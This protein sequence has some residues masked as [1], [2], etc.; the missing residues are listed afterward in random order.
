M[1]NMQSLPNKMD[2]LLSCIQFEH[3][4]KDCS[5]YCFTET[6]LDINTL[7]PAIQPQGF[8][9]FHSDCLRESTGKT[10]GGVICFLI[11]ENWCTDIDIIMNRICTADLECFLIK[12]R[13]FYLPWEFSAVFLP[14]VNIHPQADALTALD[15]L[16]DIVH[17]YDNSH[18]DATFIVAGLQNQSLKSQISPL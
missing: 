6:W 12:C 10:R 16:S 2:E 8:S 15:E 7:D 5:I 18:P 9:V 14:A 17:K 3:E 11:N 13:P 4:A 1:A